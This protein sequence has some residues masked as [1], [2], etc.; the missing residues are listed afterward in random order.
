MLE[1]GSG[2]QQIHVKADKG[3]TEADTGVPHGGLQAASSGTCRNRRGSWSSLA[4]AS[5]CSLTAVTATV[6]QSQGR[7]W[8]P[9]E[10]RS[11]NWGR[12]S[13]NS[14]DLK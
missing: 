4:Q 7:V 11:A 13:V 8:S 10:G 3:S 12:V 2:S 1:V 5:P 9:P 14:R 6:A